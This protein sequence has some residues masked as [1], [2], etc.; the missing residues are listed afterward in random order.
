MMILQVNINSKSLM[1]TLTHLL[2]EIKLQRG[3]KPWLTICQSHNLKK[4]FQRLH[5][6]LLMDRLNCKDS[7]GKITAVSNLWRTK[8]HRASPPLTWR[9]NWE[10]TNAPISN[11][12]PYINLKDLERN[13]MVFSDFLHIKTLANRS[14]I[15]CGPWRIMESLTTLWL[16][17]VLHLKKWEKP[18]MLSLEV[19]TLLK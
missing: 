16:V 14:F 7:S 6:N 3:A 12:W 4:F 2:R 19:T 17:S 11:F 1:P 8:T 18:H 15:T 10:R 5:L 13:Q 9:S